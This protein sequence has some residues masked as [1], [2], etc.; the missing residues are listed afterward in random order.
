MKRKCKNVDIT[1]IE[2][3]EHAVKDCLNGKSKK[4]RDIIELMENHDNDTH[5]IALELQSEIINR[6]LNLKPIWYKRKY[7]DTSQKWRTIGIQDIKQQIYD[8]IAVNAMAELMPRIGKYQCASIKYRGQT[9]CANAIYNHIKSD[10]IK[11][12]CKFDIKKYYESVNH[13]LLMDWLRK[14]IKNELL[15]W[16]IETLLSTFRKGLSIGSYLSQT[17]ANLFLSDL[18]HKIEA[19][20]II[21]RG[22]PKKVV[23]FQAFYMDDITIAGEDSKELI[24]V[25]KIIEEECAKISLC[26]KPNWQIINL[27]TGFIDMVG[28]RIYKD[29]ITVRRRNI[30]RIKRTVVRFRRKTSNI[31]LSKRLLSYKGILEHSNSVKFCTKYNVYELFTKAKKVVSNYDKGN[32]RFQT[33]QCLNSSC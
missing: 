5:K 2:F 15:L 19:I 3:I 22:Q 9:Y 17:L 33:A 12:A 29:H 4:R 16:L 20:H 24:Q 6:K 8:Y 31:D 25:G 27:Q 21:K 28:Y 32:V 14:H 13:Q 26:I 30:K 23:L 1:N 11:Y 7:D 10:K 18:Y